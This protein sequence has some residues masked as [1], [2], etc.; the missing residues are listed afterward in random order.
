MRIRA[1]ELDARLNITDMVAFESMATEEMAE[2]FGV[3]WA[4]AFNATGQIIAIRKTMAS[5]TRGAA[6]VTV[7]VESVN[8]NK[9]TP[10]DHEFV[11]GAHVFV[12]VADA[13]SAPA[14]ED[15]SEEDSA[16]EPMGDMP[17]P[18]SDGHMCDMPKCTAVATHVAIDM[19]GKTR[20]PVCKA[21][22][23]STRWWGVHPIEDDSEF[24]VP[25]GSTGHIAA[26]ESARRD[27]VIGADEFKIEVTRLVES[28]AELIRRGASG[29]GITLAKSGDECVSESPVA[30]ITRTPEL[31]NVGDIEVNWDV[32]FQA[33]TR[34]VEGTVDESH[35]LGPDSYQMRVR[36]IHPSGEAEWFTLPSDGVIQRLF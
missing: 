8:G 30:T 9:I 14:H 26:F 31:V 4:A 2:K 36:L 15:D 20:V 6:I 29:P 10:V 11:W 35:G 22:S 33:G 3:E 18:E 19:D 12:D 16:T 7:R 13:E 5:M 21:D 28:E 17:D 32:R 27:G 34:T 24:G 1:I 23:Y 25:V